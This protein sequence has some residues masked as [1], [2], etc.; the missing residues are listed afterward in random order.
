MFGY[1]QSTLARLPDGGH[2][3]WR[4]VRLGPTFSICCL[5]C[6]LCAHYLSQY[7][8]RNKSLDA[9]SGQLGVMATIPGAS[10]ATERLY[11]CQN[12]INCVHHART[13]DRNALCPHMHCPST[14]YLVT[15]QP[16]CK[17]YLLTCYSCVCQ[18]YQPGIKH[19]KHINFSVLI[20]CDSVKSSLMLPWYGPLNAVLW[21]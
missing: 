8:R 2:Q 15:H 9:P 16:R 1:T 7:N 18:Y 11:Y 14:T 17:L 20:S 6:P 5:P 13:K 21:S 3:G 10:S 12:T 19:G 4:D